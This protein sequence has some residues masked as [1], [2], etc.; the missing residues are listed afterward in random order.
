MDNYLS[1]H[2]LGEL[3]VRPRC[4]LRYYKDMRLWYATLFFLIVFLPSAWSADITPPTQPPHSVPS[5]PFS[6][7][8]QPDNP[9][10]TSDSEMV[11]QP[12]TIPHPDSVVTPPVIDP[13]MAIDPEAKSD[14]ERH[15]ALQP[16]ENL[17]LKK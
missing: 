13:K 8:P 10:D 17:P 14:E 15:P 4:D 12:E 2:G 1:T 3:L 16:E 9:S 7:K 6:K 5:D 11:I